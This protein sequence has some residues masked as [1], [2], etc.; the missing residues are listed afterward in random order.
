VEEPGEAM[1]RLLRDPNIASELGRKARQ[2][3]TE[4]FTI[5]KVAKDY[6]SFYGKLIT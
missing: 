4:S 3:I 1:I 5:D 2:T 6:E